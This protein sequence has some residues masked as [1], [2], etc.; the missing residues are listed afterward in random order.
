M[1]GSYLVP[2]LG[3]YRPKH[4]TVTALVAISLSG[5]HTLHSDRL[6]KIKM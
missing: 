5:T 4:F 2:F 6:A 1:A 3:E